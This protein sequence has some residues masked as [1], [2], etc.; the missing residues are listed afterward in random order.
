MENT[1]EPRTKKKE[2]KKDG[3]N[4]DKPKTKKHPNHL[5]GNEIKDWYNNRKN[6]AAEAKKQ[7]NENIENSMAI[8]KLLHK[9]ILRTTLKSK[10]QNCRVVLERINTEKINDR[11]DKKD[12]IS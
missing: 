3:I 10:K 1:Y 5:K 11:D 9:Q 12:N 2:S 8:L 4:P 6:D 7:K